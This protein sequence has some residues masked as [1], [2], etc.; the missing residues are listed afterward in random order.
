M[1]SLEKNTVSSYNQLKG[2]P[3]C[4]TMRPE[5]KGL[6][7][8]FIGN[9]IT[10]HGISEQIGW[11]RECGMAASS[12]EKDYVHLCM[13]AILK[14]DNDATFA[15]GQV[16]DWEREYRNGSKVLEKYQ[17]SRDFD[18]DIIVVRL[19][20]NCPYQDFV[21]EDF[22]HEYKAL[23]DFFNKS[24]NAKIVVTDGFWRHP[25]DASI[26]AVAEK[27][28]YPLVQLGD[29]GDNPEMKAIG[30]YEHEGVA[31]H[32]G[33]KGMANIAERIINKL[34]EENILTDKN[35]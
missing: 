27:Y 13:D 16:A 6:R 20:E 29:L 4:Y 19:I 25:G 9:S 2:A 3:C 17:A 7:V 28:G 23:I 32:P 24:G 8:L 14:Y 5:G 33:D 11:H 12:I 15:L 21:H 35:V 34:K 31:H 10:L 18:A 1:S 30:E 22:Q 26:K